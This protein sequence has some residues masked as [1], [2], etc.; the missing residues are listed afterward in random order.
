MTV[1]LIFNAAIRRGS[2]GCCRSCFD[3][4]IYSGGGC[5]Y[6][7]RNGF[8]AFIRSGSD[9]GSYRSDFNAVIRSDSRSYG[10]GFN[11][12]IYIGN[13]VRSLILFVVAVGGIVVALM[14]LF[15]VA[16]GCCI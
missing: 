14:L 11:A 13:W 10:S 8:D 1:E 5:Y 6:S 3:A 7:I 15:V 16:M 9:S 12:A 2:L 4:V